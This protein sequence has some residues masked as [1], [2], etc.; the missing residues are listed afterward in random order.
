MPT[1]PLSFTLLFMKEVP[2]SYGYL[3]SFKH[4]VLLTPVLLRLADVALI[5]N[6]GHLLGL[7]E[8]LLGF[9]GISLLDGKIANLAEQEVVELTPVGLLGVEA[10]RVLAF[11][12]EGG[13]EAPE[14]PVAAL[15]GLALLSLALAHTGLQTVVDKGA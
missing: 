8:E 14:V 10:E 12:D 15:H 6:L 9:V 13:V 11:L 1:V 2:A 5:A 7:G 4:L 3:H